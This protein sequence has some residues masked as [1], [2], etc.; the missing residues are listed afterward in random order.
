[1]ILYHGYDPEVDSLQKIKD[2]LETQ[3]TVDTLHAAT[4]Q[5]VDTDAGNVQVVHPP[6]VNYVIGHGIAGLTVDWL[7]LDDFAEQLINR[8]GL[9]SG[10]VICLIICSAGVPGGVAEQLATCIGAR[11]IGNVTVRGPRHYINWNANGEI[12]VTDYGFDADQQVKAAKTAW[13]K[14]EDKAWRTYVGLLK[15]AII[16]AIRQVPPAQTATRDQHMRTFA[17][18]RPDDN[19]QNA[20]NGLVAKLHGAPADARVKICSDIVAQSA[21]VLEYLNISG[22]PPMFDRSGTQERWSAELRTLLTDLFVIADPVNGQDTARQKVSA[23]RGKLRQ[24]L[25]AS[26]PAYSSGYYDRIRTLANGTAKQSGWSEYVSTPLV[27]TTR[28]ATAAEQV[29]TS[30][31]ETEMQE[32]ID[33]LDTL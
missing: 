9:R 24:A 16:E 15:A 29:S 28:P 18:A 8:R 33:L 21:P 10:D 6:G 25:S 1:V 32:L 14:A 19:K 3:E 7:D 11:G 13:V 30:F 26:W 22:V 5:S 27:A 23:C 12:L 2:Q 20:I 4:G 31:T 17:A